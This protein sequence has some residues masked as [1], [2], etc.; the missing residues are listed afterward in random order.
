MSNA[1]FIV[2]LFVLLST[3]CTPA[4]C[5]LQNYGVDDWTAEDF[6]K[7]FKEHANIDVP[8]S[9]IA[10]AGLHGTTFFTAR[11]IDLSALRLQPADE[12]AAKQSLDQ[13]VLRV[14]T[15]P[16]DFWEW[17][18]ANRQLL[19]NWIVPLALSPRALLIWMRYFCSEEAIGQFHAR[20]CIFSLS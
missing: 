14:N 16:V 3:S 19:D 18:A 10:S 7:H 17:R 1:Y 4:L 20:V 12:A 13:L 5:S 11:G 15:K 6:R 9:A 2:C 8:A